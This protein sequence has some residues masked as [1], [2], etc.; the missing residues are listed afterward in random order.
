MFRVLPGICLL[1]LAGCSQFTV[2]SDW[3]RSADFR[4]L[5][6]YAWL[7]LSEAA[8]ADQR[9]LDRAIDARIRTDVASCSTTDW[10]A[11]PPSR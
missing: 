11:T 1:I 10:R 8:P 4:A 5:R 6:T 9:V 3:D 7:P 2:R